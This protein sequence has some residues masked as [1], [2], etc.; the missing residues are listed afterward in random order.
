M[1]E[2][3]ET[4][5]TSGSEGGIIVKDEEYRGACRITLEK[6]SGSFVIT[7]GV[8]GA[9]VHTVFCGADCGEVYDAMKA[10]LQTFIDTETTPE[11][12]Y[13]FYHAFVSKY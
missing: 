13:A 8:Y 6:C 7:C 2:D 3:L 12:E 4:A 5:G 9:M 1:W 11:E 10:D